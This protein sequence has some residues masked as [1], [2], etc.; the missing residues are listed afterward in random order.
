MFRFLGFEIGISMRYPMKRKG[1][2]PRDS[3]SKIMM[4]AAI[5]RHSD[6]LELW[7]AVDFYQPKV[8]TLIFINGERTTQQGVENAISSWHSVCG[9]IRVIPASSKA[10]QFKM[11]LDRPHGTEVICAPFIRYRQLWM[12]VPM[13]RASG[14]K[15][16]HIS[17]CL[18]DSFG[19]TGY[20]LAYKGRY[21]RSWLALPIYKI[22]SLRNLADECFYPCAPEV[23][24]PFARITRYASRPPLAEDLFTKLSSLLKGE[25]R[26]LLIGG[27]GYDCCKMA[28][29]LGLTRYVATSKMKE[30]IIDGERIPLDSHICA[31][32]VLLTSRISQLISYTSSVVVWAK[33]WF[34][35]M[36]IQ[37][38]Q[39]SMMSKMYGP[40][41]T[42]L[43]SRTLRRMGVVVESECEPMVGSANPFEATSS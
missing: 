12:A 22:M 19:Q 42:P 10:E 13:F 37:C 23:Q 18:T 11:L 43:A 30:I 16:I 8:L 2:K 36:P 20:R 28:D 9:D 35:Q 6:L 21:L 1:M 5:E 34:P 31:E 17:D 14:I 32:E 15:T 41:F 40:L 27:F 24:N 7:S 4:I 39:S 3:A 38:Y 33:R 29:H 25:K 26:P